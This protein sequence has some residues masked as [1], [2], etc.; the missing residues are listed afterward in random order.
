MYTHVCGQF[1]KVWLSDVKKKAR[2][3]LFRKIL[4]CHRNDSERPQQQRGGGGAATGGGIQIGLRGGGVII[5]SCCCC[6]FPEDQELA[7]SIELLCK[8]SVWCGAVD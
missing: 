1:N 4:L 6:N 3:T 8:R 7:T 2:E 5:I